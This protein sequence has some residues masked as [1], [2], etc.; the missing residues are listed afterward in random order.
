MHEDVY[1]ISFSDKDA[2][3]CSNYEHVRTNGVEVELSVQRRRRGWKLSLRAAA[4]LAL[5]G[6]C[7]APDHFL[8]FFVLHRRIEVEAWDLP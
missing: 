7:W 3:P 8:L 6:A 2:H 1:C 5:H 4:E